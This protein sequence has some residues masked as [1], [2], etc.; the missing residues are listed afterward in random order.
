MGC[1]FLLKGIFPTQGANLRLLGLLHWQVDSLPLAL[2][3]NPISLGLLESLGAAPRGH[4]V[5]EP[6]AAL[7]LRVWQYWGCTRHAQPLQQPLEVGSHPVAKASRSPRFHGGT[8]IREG[9]CLGNP[10]GS[11]DSA[12]L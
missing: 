10:V 9:C 1:H 4:L 12:G 6:G 2:W 11:S 7:P 8:E 5:A 3:P